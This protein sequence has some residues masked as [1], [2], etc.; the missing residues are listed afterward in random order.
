MKSRP[1]TGTDQRP[2]GASS[3][4]VEKGIGEGT[5]LSQGTNLSRV[6]SSSG[7]PRVTSR[8]TA[9]AG[10]QGQGGTATQ[11]RQP[12]VQGPGRSCWR[13]CVGTGLSARTFG[14]SDAQDRS[15]EAV[16]GESPSFTGCPDEA[17]SRFQGHLVGHQGLAS[18]APVG[19]NDI[20]LP[21]HDPR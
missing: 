19:S 12:N 20:K 14:G 9:T 3:Y 21:L 15:S 11:G 16:R 10:A 1:A 6:G 17:T 18:G 2:R 4:S 13:R 8:H 7:N 5:Y